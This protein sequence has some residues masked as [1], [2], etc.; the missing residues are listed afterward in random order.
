MFIRGI[1]GATVVKE[2]NPET[3][4]EETKVLLTAIQ[5][6]NPGLEPESIASIF[7]TVTE[8]IN[9]SFPAKAARALG[10]RNVPL[11]C[12][13]E[14]AVPGSLKKCIRVLIHWNTERKQSEIIHVYL[15]DARK[16]RP[17]LQNSQ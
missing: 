7:F 14:I 17:D 9:S 4:I 11:M 1:R 3:I 15:G 13:Q 10:W 8:D 16:L 2:D 12:G 5:Q 6:A